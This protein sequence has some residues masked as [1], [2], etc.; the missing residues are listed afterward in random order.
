MTKEERELLML[1]TEMVCAVFRYASF[2]MSLKTQ[3]P[4][5][6]RRKKFD[7]LYVATTELL[8]RMK[9]VLTTTEKTESPQELEQS[10]Q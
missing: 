9:K 7:A 5:E 6:Q 10:S 1:V 2:E 3:E 4:P 8:D